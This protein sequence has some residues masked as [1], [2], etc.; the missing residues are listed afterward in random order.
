[1]I[2]TQ[3]HGTIGKLDIDCPSAIR[4]GQMTQDEVFVAYDAAVEGVRF[5]NESRTDPLVTLRYFGP[6][7][8]SDMPAV[9]DH[10]C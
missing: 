2:V 1:M 10:A 8:H 4:F 7:V 9:G 6:D 5:V 3:G